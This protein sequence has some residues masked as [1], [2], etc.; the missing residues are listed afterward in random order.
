MNRCAAQASEDGGRPPR[1]L[2]TM[3]RISMTQQWL[4]YS[5]PGMAEA[6]H[7]ILKVCRLSKTLQSAQTLLLR[8]PQRLAPPGRP[9]YGSSLPAIWPRIS[10]K[11]T[12]PP[13]RGG[14]ALPSLDFCAHLQGSL[15]ACLI[16]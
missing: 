16:N 3:L 15:N 14:V 11:P 13:L 4:S 1:P 5:D 7:D 2:A 6:L 10:R 8:L 9:P 12:G